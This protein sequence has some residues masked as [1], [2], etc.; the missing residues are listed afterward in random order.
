[1]SSA[2]RFPRAQCHHESLV[3][4]VSQGTPGIGRADA[5]RESGLRFVSQQQRDHASFGRERKTTPTP[6]FSSE[7]EAGELPPGRF[8]TSAAGRW[9]HKAL[10][11]IQRRSPAI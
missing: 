7:S 3:F 1:M 11:L 6:A 9:L 10:R 8:A 5:N 2:A 4:S